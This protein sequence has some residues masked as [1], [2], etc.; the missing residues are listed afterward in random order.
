[1]GF[2][3][4]FGIG[5]VA[6]VA[7][8]FVFSIIVAAVGGTIG[9]YFT[10]LTQWE[11]IFSVLFGPITITP[12]TNIFGTSIGTETVGGLISAIGAGGISGILTYIFYLVSPAVAAI[13]TGRF[14]GGK[15]FA[16]LA[17][18]LIAILS[19]AFLLIPNFL[20]LPSGAPALYYGV[21][22]LIILV[23]GAINGVFWAPFGM[24]VSE[25]EFY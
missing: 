4:G 9:T 3:K 19:A 21:I 5:L 25:A 14:A 23:P 11:N 22:I 20:A 17:W 12:W 1:M 13:L 10:T 16:F 15:R 7:L 6:F 24:A 2:A 8:N 18:F